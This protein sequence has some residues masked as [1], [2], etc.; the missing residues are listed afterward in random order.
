M[1]SDLGRPAV[2]PNY[3]KGRDFISLCSLA[4]GSKGHDLGVKTMPGEGHAASHHC[5][6]PGRRVLQN[7]VWEGCRE[8]MPGE[9][10]TVS[11]ISIDPQSCDIFHL[12]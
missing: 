12:H 1:N 4:I 7:A 2:G 8:N 3:G 10:A 6:K 5:Q 9:Y 11:T